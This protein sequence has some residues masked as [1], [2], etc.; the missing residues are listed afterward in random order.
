MLNQQTIE[1]LQSMKLYG[2]ADAFREQIETA[3]SSQLS[4]EERFAAGRSAVAW[5]E[6]RALTRRLQPP[7]SRNAA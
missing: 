1:K 6:N 2:I 4:F 3:D 5:K 7:N